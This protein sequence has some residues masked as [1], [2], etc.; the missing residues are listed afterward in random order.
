MRMAKSVT[1]PSGSVPAGTGDARSAP[2]G[3]RPRDASRRGGLILRAARRH[4]LMTLLLLAGVVLRVLAQIAY[5]PA[6]LYIDTLKY[7]YNA[8]PGS[9][10]LGYKGVLKAILLAG[11]LQAVTAVQHLVGL[12]M[13]VGIYAVVLRRGAPRWL[14]ALGAAPVLLDAYELQTEQTIMPDVWFEALIVAGLVLLLWRPRPRPWHI[15]LAGIAFGLSVT[16]AQAGEILILPAAIYAVISAG[17]W[18]R[19][20]GATALMCV[21]FA[22]PILGYMSISDAV[23]GHFWLSR[24]GET[25]IYGRVAEAADCATL[26]LPSYERALCPTAAQKALGPDGLDHAP[27]SPL[28]LYVAPPGMSQTGVVQSF[29]EAVLTQQPLRVLSATAADAARL[30]AVTRVTSPG[31]TPISRWQF[32]TYYPSYQNY[33]RTNRDDVIIVGLK[34]QNPPPNY[35]YQPLDASMGGKADVIR[36]LAVF[37]RAYQLDGGYTPGPLYLAATVL[38]LAGTLALL[39]R[40]T[41]ANDPDRGLAFA[42]CLFFLTAAAI[43]L[44]SDIP[45]FSWRYQLPA[46]Q[47]L[48][49]A[50][51]LGLAV[52]LAGLRGRRRRPVTAMA[53]TA[54][55]GSPGSPGEPVARG[56]ADTAANGSAPRAGTVT[57]EGAIAPGRAVTASVPAGTERHAGTATA[58]D[59]VDTAPDGVAT[60]DPDPD[61]AGSAAP[62][63]A[64]DLDGGAPGSGSGRARP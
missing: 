32:Q 19:A 38:G 41:R 6:L 39:R 59:A 15:A 3:A 47:T 37:L 25:T 45:E 46:I 63:A 64:G 4:W 22:V 43:L 57:Q 27:S 40:R 21:S 55:A 18:R 17:G 28:T 31:D 20:I 24:S 30:F 50:G 10:P 54:P 53:T 58:V 23:S 44:F 8:W 42:C 12:A 5:R 56:T 62:D 26:N 16:V 48:P 1:G 2:P 49:P 35:V 34:V 61:S 52:I 36:P 11:N 29:T 33:I 14:A 60:P 9:D 7:L 13:G 51:A